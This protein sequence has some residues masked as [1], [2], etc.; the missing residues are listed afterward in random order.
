MSAQEE[1]VKNA[2]LIAASG[3][4][5]LAA[6][7]STG[8]IAKRFQSI[9]LE[10]N[11]ENRRTYREL[12]FTAPGLSQ[13]VSGVILY[14]E[15]LHQKTK[16]GKPFVEV[17]TSQGILPGIK[18]DAGLKD[19]PGTN[20]QY[21]TGLDGL[22]ERAQKY[23]AAGCRFAKWRAAYSIDVKHGKPS[24]VIIDTQA[25]DL[26]RYAKICQAAKLVPI[27]EPEVMMDGDHDI[28]TCAR[29]SEK[30]WAAV[31]TAL[32]DYDVF[33]EGCLLKPNMVTPGQ[34]HSTFKT[35]SPH[36]VASYTIR[37]LKRTIPTAIP[38]I[39]FLS[40]GQNEEEATLNLDAMNRIQTPWR[41]SFSYGRALQ[42]TCLQT[43]LGKPENY[44]TAQA[45][46]SERVKANGDA[47]LGKYQGGAGGDKA[48]V[49]LFEEGYIY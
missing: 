16:D 38:G 21:C 23:Y 43:W 30:V 9:K 28:D 1:L 26:A 6:D 3:K 41:L 14:D 47:Q 4:G 42:S 31:T 44:K 45:A 19:L 49:S 27:V 11:E 25:Q 22:L 7:E 18:V 5:I 15:T 17:L 29:I 13:Y 35:I 8:T 40:G 48:K 32:H 39:M 37:S 20:E 10:N 33:L 12:L 46:F 36:V 24:Q 2:R 34:A